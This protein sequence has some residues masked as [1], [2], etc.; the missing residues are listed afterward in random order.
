MVA[1]L[2]VVQ[3]LPNQPGPVEIIVTAPDL[4]EGRLKL[5]AN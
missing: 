5:R 3:S 1:P 2:A 4:P